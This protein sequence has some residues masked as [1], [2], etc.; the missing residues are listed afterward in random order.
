[1]KTT[2]IAT[3]TQQESNGIPEI[4]S[5]T[6]ETQQPLTS[7]TTKGDSIIYTGLI[8]ILVST[9]I[10]LLPDI[11]P[12]GFTN[13][14]FMGLFFFN[15]VIASVFLCVI[16]VDSFQKFRWSLSK[17]KV[18]YS[19]LQLILYMIS[20]FALNRELTV[21]EQSASWVCVFLV[22]QS[23]TLMVLAF[24]K[25]FHPALVYSLCVVLGCGISV[26][27]YYA[28]YL[29]PMYL[30]G[31]IA[32]PLLGISLHVFT[33]LLFVIF[34]VLL[35]SKIK[36][37][38]WMAHYMFLAGLTVPVIATSIFLIQWKKYTLDMNFIMNEN[39]VN[40]STLPLWTV[41]SQEMDKNSITEKLLKTDL[42]YSTPSSDNSW[43]WS[44]PNNSFDEVRKHD[45]LVM[46]STFICGKPELSEKE[47]IKV[48]ESMYDARH[49]AQERLWTGNLLE[50][51]N[52][53]SN[54]R[55]FPEHRIAYT[56][57]VISIKS[58]VV[59]RWRSQQEAIFTFHLPEGGVVTSLSLWINGKEEKGI[60][61]TKEKAIN[62]YNTIVGVEKRDPSVI[63]WRE[64]NTVSVRVFPCTPDEIRRFKIGVTAPLKVEGG[65]LAYENIYFDGPPCKG[66]TES[67]NVRFTSPPGNLNSSFNFTETSANT[68]KANKKYESYWELKFD[69]PDLSK[70]GFS[71][72][73]CNYKI[74]NYEKQYES[75]SPET[76]YLDLNSS[77]T[78]EEL[79]R[80]WEKLRNKDVFVYDRQMIRMKDEN[81]VEIFNAS[82]KLNFSLFP[83]NKIKD[84][85]NSLF[86]TKSTSTSPNLQDVKESEFSDQLVSYLQNNTGVRM[87]NIGNELSPFLK[88]LKEL[89]V[90]IYDN[91][92]VADL[93]KVLDNK[94]FVKSQETASKIVIDNAGIIIS[95]TGEIAN[96]GAPDHLLRLFAYNHI[97]ST[98]SS[99]YFRDSNYSSE[100]VAEAQKAYVV[101]PVSSLIVL[102]TQQ[103]Y[104]RFDIQDNQNSLKNAST[105]SSGAVP[106]PHEWM[107]IIISACVVLYFIYKSN[108][109]V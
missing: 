43:F 94:T 29:I 10:F 31:L 87:F 101:S 68:I 6:P 15:Y 69:L 58:N 21:F 96:V 30:I 63:Q 107:L 50:I 24:R 105:K 23:I 34:N 45:P 100:A 81:M 49:Q 76:Y 7:K 44:M 41:L 17:N 85:A 14:S 47:K 106:E 60:M 33:P 70:K 74:E 26:Y 89:R 102:E 108:F 13:E 83:I 54:I 42:I 35:V 65:Q 64:G 98:L 46:I 20:A 25:W 79:F 91:G 62:A 38:N 48:L 18:E 59:Q 77:W 97:M 86:I 5:V 95:E 8:L 36:Q 27:V 40:E 4:I 56:E 3:T 37:K 88:S 93:E 57:K 2:N 39:I 66:T 32:T 78:Q 109:S 16:F 67:V 12:S 1:M 51:S 53:I 71:F 22:T 19:L 61:T 52:V 75:F 104:D 73:G 28:I 92:S 72:D 11:N 99:N 55:V 9:F 82:Q 103:D 90:F 80:V 84:P